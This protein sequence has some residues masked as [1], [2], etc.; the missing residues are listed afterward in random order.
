LV[1]SVAAGVVACELACLASNVHAA[2]FAVFKIPKKEDPL[3]KVEKFPAPEGPREGAVPGPKQRGS[4]QLPEDW[5]ED[6]DMYWVPPPKKM[7]W[8]Q[9]QSDTYDPK[10]VKRRRNIYQNAFNRRK[11][12]RHGKAV[13]PERSPPEAMLAGGDRSDLMPL[14][15]QAEDWS[16]EFRELWPREWDL[17]GYWDECNKWSGKDYLEDMYPEYDPMTSQSPKHLPGLPATYQAMR[18]LILLERPG[19]GAPSLDKRVIQ[20]G[21][22]FAAD[23]MIFAGRV[24]GKD[25]HF[26]KCKRPHTL[27]LR[28]EWDEGQ[29]CGEGGWI[30]STDI[31]PGSPNFMSD[32]IK[33]IKYMRL[34]KDRHRNE[35]RK[36]VTVFSSK[37]RHPKMPLRNAGGM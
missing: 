20:I 14:L 3:I 9:Q 31:L 27:E 10:R 13:E 24:K 8:S 15:D 22:V 21:T 4:D 2:A 18:P 29:D 6:G 26:I 7:P 23:K 25:I 30:C 37:N 28:P 35:Q 11:A 16:T 17:R 1:L 36:E 34:F 32:K 19:F 33:K 12:G 5:Y